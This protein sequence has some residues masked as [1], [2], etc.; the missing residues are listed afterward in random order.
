MDKGRKNRGYEK[1]RINERNTKLIINMVNKIKDRDKRSS[2][3]NA[4]EIKRWI[5]TTKAKPKE[6]F[7]MA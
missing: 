1:L 6:K 3:R 7:N 2:T 5:N 4:R